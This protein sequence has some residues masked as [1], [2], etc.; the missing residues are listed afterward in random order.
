MSHG[1]NSILCVRRPPRP[2]SSADYVSCQHLQQ[3]DRD[4]EIICTVCGLWLGVVFVTDWMP[5]IRPVYPAVY[6]RLRYITKRLTALRCDEHIW[7]DKS[8]LW[9]LKFLPNPATWK[10]IYVWYRDHLYTAIRYESFAYMLG[11]TYY[12]LVP[13]HEVMRAII[14]FDDVNPLPH[15]N[16]KKKMN[17]W[18]LVY[19]VLSLMQNHSSLTDPNAIPL[20]LAPA[21]LAKL[22]KRFGELTELPEI[23]AS[24]P[25]I[26]ESHRR[27]K[28]L[29]LPMYD[30]MAQ[31]Q[32]KHPGHTQPWEPYEEMFGDSVDS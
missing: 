9:R 3:D 11:E 19:R 22:D 25:E 20:K 6:I 10:D 16:V 4:G 8:L 29:C 27:R 1:P 24:F 14:A 13:D 32:R 28:T 17:L 18:F 23:R 5:T 31:L 12:D 2:H 15:W 26:Y 21:T 30:W 7:D